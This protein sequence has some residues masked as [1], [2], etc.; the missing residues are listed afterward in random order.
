[1]RG[2]VPRRRLFQVL[3]DVPPGA[4][5]LV[6][7]PAGSGKTV[8]LRSWVEAEGIAERVAWVSV[9]RGES[10]PQ[11]FWLAV[12]DALA[13][14][15]AGGEAVH[16][17]AP[18]PDFRGRAMVEGLLADLWSLEEQVVLVVDDVHEL[19]SSEAL[20]LFEFFLRE[21]PPYVTV[22][23]STREEVRAGLHRLRLTGELTEIRARDMRF[24]RKETAALLRDAGFDLSDRAV[25]SLHERTEGWA[26]GVRL[27]SISLTGRA[28]PERFVNEF[29]GSERTVAGYLM[30]EVLEL[31]PPEVRELLLQTSNLERVSGPLADFL[32]GSSGSERILQQLEDANAFVT[33]LD[34]G[35][36]WFRYH[37]LFA[38]LLQLELRR[39]EPSAIGPL[40]RAAAEWHERH[41][42]VVE[43]VG[44]AQAARDWPLASRLLADKHLDLTLDGRSGA[45]SELLS[46]F[47]RD[48]AAADPELALVS[49]TVCLLRG[50]I[51][52]SAARVE[53]AQRQAS[54]VRPERRTNFELFLELLALVLA[55][56]R[57]D[58][59][60]VLEAKHRFEADLAA[61][62]AGE[63]ALRDEYN[64]ITLQ[65]LGVAELWSVQPEAAR[66]ELERALALAQ[67]AGRPWLA[68][69]SFG[70]LGIAVPW[71]G[72]SFTAGLRMSEEGVKLA[73]THGWPEDPV[74]VTALA[75]GAVALLWL[76][77][78]AEAERW[79]DR[80]QRTLNPDGEPASE[81]IVHEA[82]GL[83]RLVQGRLDDA[84]A[85]FRAA[86]R[87]QALLM[88]KHPF[89]VAA[90]ARVLQTL[91]RTGQ[92][93]AARAAF[94]DVS[95]DERDVADF[96]LSAA[97]I[98]LAAG[99][100]HAA[101]D[102]LG[103]VIAGE[104][105]TI[106][107]PAPA[108]EAQ[109]LDA[110]ARD[111]AGDARA[112]DASIERALELAE[113]DGL[114]LPFAIE[115]ARRLLE[116]HRHRSAHPTLLATILDVLAGDSRAPESAPG[117]LRDDLSEAELRVLR[118]LPGNLKAPEIASELFVSNNTVR[119]HLRHIYSKLDAHTRSEAVARARQLRLIGPSSGLR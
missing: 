115:P 68:I 52:E 4:V 62:P 23:L 43:A 89:A 86:E 55:R 82:M 22:V 14:T 26:A 70:H 78:F 11:R 15:A 118:Y 40:H 69:A 44:H 12:I 113:P 58:L 54:E 30:A 27:A 66:R 101:I 97:V 59:E 57:G 10:D 60:T 53:L 81:L 72:Q 19:R 7:A 96:R 35:R 95:E 116:R 5:A 73:D 114:L 104:A 1:M 111:Q 84:L 56:W 33:S 36:T 48:V 67:R 92:L 64:S 8:L 77:R 3:S 9:E 17:P 46:A 28:D 65:H 83:L 85:A 103:P 91:A 37:H 106:H 32:T 49:A 119:T 74:I 112:A 63:L 109:L 42:Y 29:S 24:S 98:H 76:G 87:M 47:P 20:D 102:V 41:G 105:P 90:R 108:T 93:A 61:Q 16:R 13:T 31:Q 71:T 18:S 107:P 99:E 117:A 80:A 39:T 25:D 45:V 88:S 21:L 34:V 38:D 110:I 100:P 50:E 79:L 51:D 6:C 2:L 75:T 94:A